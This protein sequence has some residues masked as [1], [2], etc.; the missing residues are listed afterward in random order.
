MYLF[1]LPVYLMHKP[2][3]T[4][5][6]GMALSIDELPGEDAEQL[7][8]WLE[9]ILDAE[10]H[11]QFWNDHKFVSIFIFG[12]ALQACNTCNPI[13]TAAKT[14]QRLA[15][16]KIANN[17]GSEPNNWSM[18]SVAGANHAIEITNPNG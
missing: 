17:T 2:L 18:R 16:D 14:L 1:L 13:G 6:N 8:A 3:S 12:S 4:V 10:A 5:V 7:K 9:P 11:Y 15:Q